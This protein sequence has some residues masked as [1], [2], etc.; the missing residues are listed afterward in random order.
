[1]IEFTTSSGAWYQIE[2]HEP[3]RWRARRVEGE[4]SEGIDYVLT[5]DNEWFDLDFM[6]VIRVGLSAFLARPDGG[7]WRI[8]TEVVSILDD[9]V[10]GV[11]TEP[12]GVEDEF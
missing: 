10:A 4:H 11:Q 1:M 3:R 12:T 6:P 2:E 8:T 5:E 9:E 7:P